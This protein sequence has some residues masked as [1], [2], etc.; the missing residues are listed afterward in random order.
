VRPLRSVAVTA[1]G[2]LLAAGCG[3]ASASVAGAGRADGPALFREATERVG[4]DFTHHV[5]V[6]G[7]YALTELMGSGCAVFD[8]DGDGRLDLFF[9]DAGESREKGAPDRL[10]LR[11]P[12]GRYRDATEGAGLDRNGYGT[13]VAAGDLD[14]DGDVDL[15]V[16]NLGGDRLYLNDGAG[17]FT[18][19][20][21]RAGIRNQRWTASVG[22]VDFDLDGFLDVFVT[23]YVRYDPARVCA[24]T[25]GRR[26]YCGPEVYESEVDVLYRNKGDGTFED[27][28]DRSGIAAV[29][30]QGLGV[31]VEDF[32]ADGRPD[33]YVA[34]D[35]QANN[36]W[37]NRGDGRFEDA[38]LAMGVAVNGAGVAQASMGVAAGDVD[39][40]D[41]VDLFITNIVNECNVLYSRVDSF[42]FRDATAAA[43]LAP[44]SRAHTGFGA[45]MLDADL[46]GDLDIAV[47]N[48]RVARGAPV[49]GASLGSHWN[50]YADHNQLFLN[51]GRGTYVESG[52]GDFASHAEVGRALAA[53][54][55]DDDGDLDLVMTGVGTP[56]RVFENVQQGGGHW[57]AVRVLDDRLKRDAFGAR[58]TVLAGGSRRQRTASS[59]VSYFTSCV[60]PLHFG[61]GPDA[62]F[63]AIEVVWPGGAVET[64]PGGPADRRVTLVRG[65]GRGR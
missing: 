4:L 53:A 27:V 59:A 52:A 8:A 45:A 3:D 23:T 60:T 57:L 65:S 16:G 61:L 49:P 58:V 20:T 11:T 50:E 54:D 35:G 13:G 17:R 12:D 44:P 32:D 39:G 25:N 41:D 10:F 21:A 1:F 30:R 48:G 14:N 56:A 6:A 34:N 38:A 29:A 62:T 33:V 43:A 15:Y 28:S 51:G 22:L 18:D 64:F 2:A 31:I 36:L 42:G 55:L 9:V 47:A 63:D 26:D 7:D 37:I 40:D 5:T 46:D 24:L 19:V